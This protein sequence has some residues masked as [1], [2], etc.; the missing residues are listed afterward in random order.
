M[1]LAVSDLGFLFLLLAALCL[2]DPAA[3]QYR[4]PEQAQA[5]A[6]DAR[7]AEL[8]AATEQIRSEANPIADSSAAAQS[9]LLVD[10]VRS[11]YGSDSALYLRELE[12]HAR[13][14]GG[15]GS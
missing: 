14:L 1:R 4:W 8:L 2:A 11:R 7:Y 13:D 12:A 15:C 9:K 10:Y 5:A 3:A 6:E